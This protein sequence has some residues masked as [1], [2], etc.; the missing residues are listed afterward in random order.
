MDK[1]DA[2]VDGTEWETGSQARENTRSDN[3]THRTGTGDGVTPS[4][5]PIEG[6]DK[7]S[8]LNLT[9]PHSRKRTRQVWWHSLFSRDLGP[10][11]HCRP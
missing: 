1:E 6:L 4:A 10:G 9:I 8:I 3:K 2:A 11:S 5:L 7:D